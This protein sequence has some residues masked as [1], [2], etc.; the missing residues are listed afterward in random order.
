MILNQTNFIAIYDENN[1]LDVNYF[2]KMQFIMKKLLFIGFL[3]DIRIYLIFKFILEI[4][5]LTII[6][7]LLYYKIID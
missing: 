6:I 5:A 1:D 2:K 7:I 3:L 4:D